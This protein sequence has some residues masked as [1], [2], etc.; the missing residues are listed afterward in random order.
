[1]WEGARLLRYTAQGRV[2][3]GLTHTLVGGRDL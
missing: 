3:K 2:E 1:M